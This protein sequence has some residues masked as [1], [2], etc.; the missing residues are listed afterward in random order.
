MEA[1]SQDSLQF[2]LQ[3]SQEAWKFLTSYLPYS[4]AARE[5]MRLKALAEFGALAKPILDVGCGDGLFW[6]CVIRSGDK[7]SRKLSGLLG[8]DISSDELNLASLRLQEHGGQVVNRD[9]C[10][11]RPLDP[12]QNVQFRSVIANCSLEHVSSIETA[13]RNIF[14]M[15]AKDGVFLL[16][17]PVPRWTDTLRF[18]R[19]AGKV[20]HRIGGF[21]GGALDGF[22][23]H[24]HLYPAEV[25]RF[26]LEGIGFK[27]ERILGVGAPAA[28]SVFE[29]YLP[30]AFMSFVYKLFLG[31]YP[32]W[33]LNLGTSGSV[34]KFLNELE[35]GRVIESNLES[36]D[37]VEYF[38]VCR[39][40]PTTS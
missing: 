28:N 13:L 10:S 26:L 7:T 6:E 32:R 21:A 31:R 9:I 27:V 15:M 30:T 22:F 12:N 29:R 11:N 38:I 5:L 17:V 14:A 19:V 25:W 35:T 2:K 20:S 3:Q 40:A 39:K 34:K 37:I 16:F 18:K 4:L 24:N 36:P 1:P 33:R 8:I 23:Q